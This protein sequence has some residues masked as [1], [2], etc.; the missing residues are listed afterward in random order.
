MCRFQ[1][2]YCWLRV[3]FGSP[4]RHLGLPAVL[5]PCMA[6]GAHKILWSIA[7]HPSSSLTDGQ[8]QRI[9][10]ALRN[11]RAQKRKRP[12]PWFTALT[13]TAP[14]PG[15]LVETLYKWKRNFCCVCLLK[16]LAYQITILSIILQ[17]ALRTFWSLRDNSESCGPWAST[18]V[19]P[20]FLGVL[21]CATGL[22]RTNC[23]FYRWSFPWSP[24]PVW[25]LLLLIFCPSRSGE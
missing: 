6:Q 12:G 19:S 13:R 9:P 20:S 8:L 2:L 10:Q 14:W 21:A 5:Y 4:G 18:L 23:W 16:P 7:P 24:T 1:S 3:I 22:L 15:T 25:F 11:G 17:A